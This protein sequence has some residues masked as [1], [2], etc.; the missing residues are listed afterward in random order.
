MIVGSNCPKR[1]VSIDDTDIDLVVFVADYLYCILSC[2]FVYG[3][4]QFSKSFVLNALCRSHPK[5]YNNYECPSGDASSK[6][7]KIQVP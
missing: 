5:R 3:R 6:E 1:I 2:V 7:K 4:F